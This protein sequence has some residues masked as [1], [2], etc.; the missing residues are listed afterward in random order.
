MT[1]GFI[2]M[3]GKAFGRSHSHTGTYKTTTGQLCVNM[4]E[5]RFVEKANF[6]YEERYFDLIDVPYTHVMHMCL[7]LDLI[8]SFFA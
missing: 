2:E 4:P 7:V 3:E 8:H 6:I 5:I 1:F